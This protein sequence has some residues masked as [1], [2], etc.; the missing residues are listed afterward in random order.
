ML[1]DLCYKISQNK[2]LLMFLT[3]SVYILALFATLCGLSQIFAIIFTTLLL[4]ALF[5]D[6]FPA[7]Y[8]LV[9]A[10]IFYLGI[11]NT[12]SRLKNTDD[13]LNLAPQ[14]STI[15]GKVLSIP[16]NKGEDK[17]KFFFRVDKIEYDNEIQELKMKRL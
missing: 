16:K 6:L 4:T 10:F 14:N 17:T 13:L 8:I 7:K 11:F 2:N 5:T 15:Y 9:W 1:K 3:V 12:S